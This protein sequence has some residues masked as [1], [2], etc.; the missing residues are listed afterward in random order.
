MTKF[1]TTQNNH[2]SGTQKYYN[3]NWNNLSPGLDAS[4]DLQPGNRAGLFPK[5]KISKDVD[6]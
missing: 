3:L 1:I 5:E 2:A 6:K 4:Y